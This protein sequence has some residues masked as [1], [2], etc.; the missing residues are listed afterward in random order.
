MFPDTA[1]VS[2]AGAA[3]PAPRYED[4]LIRRGLC[5]VRNHPGD[6]QAAEALAALLFPRDTVTDAPHPFDPVLRDLAAGLR[7]CLNPATE[8]A[9]WTRVTDLL[10]RILIAAP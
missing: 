4:S 3:L 9:H 10:R 2:L 8:P 5:I 7:L 6:P 1:I